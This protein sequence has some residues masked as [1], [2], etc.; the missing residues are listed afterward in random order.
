MREGQYDIIFMDC[1][2]PEM[3]GFEATHLIRK[4]EQPHHRHATIVALTAD[5]MTATVKND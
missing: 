2:M 4:E 3:D 1:Q 5:A